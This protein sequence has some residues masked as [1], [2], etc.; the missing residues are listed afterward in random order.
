MKC[1]YLKVLA[2]LGA[3]TLAVPRAANASL[4]DSADFTY[5]Y[6]MNDEPSDVDA[7]GNSTNDFQRIVNSPATAAV[8]GGILTLD[9]AGAGNN[10]LATY[11]VSNT[12]SQVWLNSG[13]S[14]ATG[15]TI[16]ARLKVTADSTFG[17]WGAGWIFAGTS[18]AVG[19]SVYINF[20]EDGLGWGGANTPILAIDTTD[21]F[22]VYRLAL[23][24]GL[25]SL[26]VDGALITST[27]VADAAGGA[28]E[29]Y[30]GDAGSNWNGI[31]EVDYFR[32][33]S[34]AFAPVPEPSS[35]VLF[36]TAT[37]GA[38]GFVRRKR[39]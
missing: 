12:A 7:D 3:V 2:I 24:D 8:S 28:Y 13:I 36:L 30:L 6:E 15:Y 27:L 11:Y 37:A 1:D 32:F 34:G 16:E 35:A 39:K 19:E 18:A 26:W 10:P 33:T 29:L 38:L 22:H 9:G 14:Q 4:L 25:Y 20:M 31:M 23:K 17:I 5:K 21:D